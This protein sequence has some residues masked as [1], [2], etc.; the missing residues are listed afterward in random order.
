FTARD[1]KDL[2]AAVDDAVVLGNQGLHAPQYAHD[3]VGKAFFRLRNVLQL[4][5]DQGAA[6][7]DLE[8][9]QLHAAVDEIKHLRRGRT[10]DQPYNLHGRDA[11]R[12]NHQ[13][14]AE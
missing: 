8:T 12:I 14:D 13:V 2:V 11:F 3:A 1:H 4:L 7:I 9:E 5:A 10:P 6:R